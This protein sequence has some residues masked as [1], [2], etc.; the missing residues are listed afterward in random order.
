MERP[1]LVWFMEAR[2]SVL[3][4]IFKRETNIFDNFAGEVLER[5]RGLD[6]MVLLCNGPR[7]CEIVCVNRVGG[8]R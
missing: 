8:F 7:H 1:D 4:E 3:K 6:E 2:L 5:Y